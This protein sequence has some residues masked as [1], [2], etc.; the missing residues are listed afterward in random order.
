MGTESVI[1]FVDKMM[2]AMPAEDLAEELVQVLHRTMDTE[3]QQRRKREL[4]RDF[5]PDDEALLERYYCTGV[6]I[7]RRLYTRTTVTQLHDTYA[8]LKVRSLA[9][10][11]CDCRSILPSMA[12]TRK[13]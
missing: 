10:M 3:R 6:E 8:G 2:D 4:E 13:V 12:S 5:D 9:S 1:R 11:L 7:S